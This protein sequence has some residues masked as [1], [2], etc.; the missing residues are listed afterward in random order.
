MTLDAAESRSWELVSV[1]YV[2]LLTRFV[3]L[4]PCRRACFKHAASANSVPL[5]LTCSD[6]PAVCSLQCSL[7]ANTV[8]AGATTTL[9]V[10]VLVIAYVRHSSVLVTLHSGNEK[11]LKRRVI[12]IEIFSVT[13]QSMLCLCTFMFMVKRKPFCREETTRCY[14]N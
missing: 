7:S 6:L 11:H 14:P 2:C 9:F 12:T 3:V 5:S 8:R 1:C 4:S 13:E 10:V